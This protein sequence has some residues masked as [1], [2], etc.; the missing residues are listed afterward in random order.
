M[1]AGGLEPHAP[2]PAHEKLNDMAD[3][4]VACADSTAASIAAI[5]KVHRIGFLLSIF[6]LLTFQSLARPGGRK[7]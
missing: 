4:A 5:R 1:K 6:L 3:A 2:T 7:N